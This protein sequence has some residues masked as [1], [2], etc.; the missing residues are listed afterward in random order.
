MFSYPWGYM[1]MYVVGNENAFHSAPPRAS[2]GGERYGD[3][4][5][6]LTGFGQSKRGVSL[7]HGVVTSIL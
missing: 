4:A 2:G 3:T 5:N 1:V 7:R 6:T